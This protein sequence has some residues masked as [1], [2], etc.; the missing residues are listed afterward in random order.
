MPFSYKDLTYIRAAIQAYGAA[1]SEV[2]EDECNDEDEFSEIQDDRQY[3]D[4]LLALVSNEIEKLEGSKPS[5][6]PI[7]NDKE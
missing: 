2:S 5:L 7:K 3:L 1:L 4:R 6:N